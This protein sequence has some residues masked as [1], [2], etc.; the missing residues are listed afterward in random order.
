MNAIE[1][2]LFANFIGKE[3]VIMNILIKEKARLTNG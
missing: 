1:I 2:N 3:D